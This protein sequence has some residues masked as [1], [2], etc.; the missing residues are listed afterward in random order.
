MWGVPILSSSF[1]F[2]E[3][4]VKSDRPPGVLALEAPPRIYASLVKADS[5]SIVLFSLCRSWT[6]GNPAKIEMRLN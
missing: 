1:F 6:N 5:L 2:V 3:S 4:N